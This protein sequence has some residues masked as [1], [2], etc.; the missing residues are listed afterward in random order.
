MKEFYR[1]YF[2]I[3]IP[4]EDEICILWEQLA[5]VSAYFQA[6]LLRNEMIYATN[7]YRLECRYQRVDARLLSKK[8]ERSDSI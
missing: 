6:E 3:R 4:L 1:F 8:T 2:L 5:L 7:S